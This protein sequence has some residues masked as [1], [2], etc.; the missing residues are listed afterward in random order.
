MPTGALAACALQGS[1]A[2]RRSS[3]STA[4]SASGGDI[5]VLILGAPDRDELYEALGV[6]ERRLGR[7]VQATLREPDWLR[8]GSGSFHDTVKDRPLIR[9]QIRQI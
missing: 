9:L 4:R 3:R 6:A 7:P 8:S 1:P 2:S 5:D